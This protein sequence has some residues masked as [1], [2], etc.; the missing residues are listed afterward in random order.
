MST[1]KDEDICD[2]VPYLKLKD[3]L[4]LPLENS[5][6]S[7]KQCFM[8]PNSVILK[9]RLSVLFLAFYEA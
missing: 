5:I 3:N 7:G 9:T 2:T 1:A 4:Y 8:H 6:Y